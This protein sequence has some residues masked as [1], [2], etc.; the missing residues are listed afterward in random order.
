MKQVPPEFYQ[1]MEQLQAV[2]FVLVEL[3]LY[4]D[5]HPQDS[6][7]INQFNSCAK[8]R[9]RLKKLFESQFGPLMQ[10]GNSYSGYPWNWNDPPWPWQL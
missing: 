6:E 2:D 4:L 1:L 5:T 7:A 10:Y 8:E 3:T 9:K